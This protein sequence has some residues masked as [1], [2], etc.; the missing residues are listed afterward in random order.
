MVHTGPDEAPA[1]DAG[2][3]S[4]AFLAGLRGLHGRHAVLVSHTAIVPFS[5]RLLVHT[6]RGPRL[7]LHELRTRGQ[8]GNEVSVIET[9]P[10]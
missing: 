5:S 2:P 4:P 6:A 9:K 8:P 7:V 1:F 10:I 3:G